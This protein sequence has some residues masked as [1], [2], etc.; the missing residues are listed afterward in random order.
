MPRPISPHPA[1]DE[2]LATM[3]ARLAADWGLWVYSK[4]SCG[5]SS[6]SGLRLMLETRPDIAHCRVNDIAERLRCKACT[7]PFDEVALSDGGRCGPYMAN[8]Q[9]PLLSRAKPDWRS[10][11]DQPRDTAEP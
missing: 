2:K 10:E 9:L 4:C 7:K 11:Q 8:W 3:P 5:A 1:L 6:V